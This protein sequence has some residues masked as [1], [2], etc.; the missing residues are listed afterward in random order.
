MA[1][2]STQ[3]TRKLG[4]ERE[5]TTELKALSG[6]LRADPS[7]PA[8]MR[9]GESQLEL[10]SDLFQKISKNTAQDSID[11]SSVFQLLP[12]VELTEQILVGSI[13]SPKD[14]SSTELGFSVDPALFDGGAARALLGILET[15]FKNVYK[16]DDRLDGMLEE[17]LFT[18]GAYI[19]AILPENN[20]DQMINSNTTLSNESYS[21][22]IDRARRGQPLGLLGHPRDQRVSMESHR[23]RSGHASQIQGPAGDR[24]RQTSHLPGLSVSDN[25]DLLKTPNVATQRRK[26]AI[27]RLIGNHNVSMESAVKGMSPEDIDKLYAKRNDTAEPVQ[28]L[29]PQNYLNR[30]SAGHPLML[31]LPVESVI[32]V[33]PPGEPENH[34]G[35]FLL[36]DKDNRPVQ[37]EEDRDYYG[38]LR[39]SFGQDQPEQSSDLVR[40]VK[41]AMGGAVDQKGKDYDQ[42]E[43]A[44]GTIIENDLINRLRNGIYDE[45]FSLG[46]SQDIQRIMLYRSLQAKQTQLLYI[47]EELM[48]YMAF[49]YNQYGIGESLLTKSKILSSMRTVLM[50]ADT[51]SGVRNA[52]GRKKATIT[53]D[54]ADPDPMKTI[55]DTQSLILEMSRNGFP[56]ASPDPGQTLDYLNRAGY[57]WNIDVQGD[58]LP[59]TKVEFDDYNTQQ[60]GGNPDLQDR[61]RRQHI[62]GLGMNPELVDPTS[63]PDFAT[64]V[65]NN[66]LIMTR[67]VIRYQKKFTRF[68]TRMI[69]IFTQ[70]SSILR[71]EMEEVLKSNKTKLTPAQKKLETAEVIDEFLDAFSVSLPSPDTTRMDLQL[72]AFEQY[73]NLLDRAI[74]AYVTPDLIP[75]EYLAREPD[76]VNHLITTMSA[77]FKR[78]WLE[79]NN[80]MP[81]LDQLMELDEKSGKSAFSLLDIQQGVR[82]SLGSAMQE[83][84]EAYVKE[85]EDFEKKYGQDGTDLGGGDGDTDGFGDDSWGSADG[86]GDEGTTA[87]DEEPEEEEVTDEGEEADPLAEEEENSSEE[88]PDDTSDKEDKQ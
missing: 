57:D 58:N 22:V 65:V 26:A 77:Y 25:F 86:E 61:L 72:Q 1:A 55:S 41:E 84:V 60:S 9:P 56:V 83:Y 33:F 10:S 32:P 21:Y 59:G 76:I 88:E 36:L 74:E 48:V 17:I 30:A 44:Y 23:D 4:F 8:S 71:A 42:I 87:G 12:D 64:S 68:L 49:N 38:E 34:I 53:V 19:Q 50:F 15:H 14:M 7:K 40:K 46:F 27:G 13:L 31:K 45:E 28:Q 80:V 85:K 6:K 62:S 43:K 51:M 24:H 69:R 47:P 20:L 79:N 67:R 70:H 39:S 73:S 29:T 16:I 11:A 5:A 18:E 81:E 82:K 2:K 3:Q 63:S 52:V 37:R 78:M 54:E 66:N 35:Y 75:P